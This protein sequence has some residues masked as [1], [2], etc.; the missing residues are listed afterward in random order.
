[1]VKLDPRATKSSRSK[2]P[3]TGNPELDAQIESVVQ[4]LAPA[5]SRIAFET[6]ATAIKLSGEDLQRLDRKIVNSTLKELR[7]A[8]RVFAPYRGI[9]KVSIFGSARTDP[10]EPEYRVAVEFARAMAAHHW[11]VI[12]G[13]GQGI[14]E[15]GHEGAGREG[16]F[17]ANIRLPMEARPNPVIAEDEKLINFKYFFTRKLTF[18]KEADAFVLFPGGFGTLDEAFELLTLTQ[19][20]KSDLHPIVLLDRPGGTY[21][22]RFDEYVRGELLTRGLI[23]EEDLSLYRAVDTVPEAVNEIQSFYNVYHSQ[24]VVDGHLVL[25]LNFAPGEEEL[26][27]LSE[28]FSGAIE[29]PME[30]VPPSKVEIRD[31]DFPDLPRIAVNFRD[32][33]GVLRTLIDR[34]NQLPAR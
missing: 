4:G 17:G 27:K 12:T 3:S 8:F 1:M 31:E 24:R 20:G 25:R 5:E 26:A 13:A 16:S 11:M 2:R 30:L 7:Y 15:A 9:R 19:T 10:Q 18:I 6:I 32:C 33:P 22:K 29:G 21:W 28:E 23:S 14:M 34:L